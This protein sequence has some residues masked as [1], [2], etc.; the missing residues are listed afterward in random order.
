[1]KSNYLDL[2]VSDFS[3]ELCIHIRGYKVNDERASTYITPL[4]IFKETP[5]FILKLEKGV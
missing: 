1:M 5:N 3:G 2:Q 4:L